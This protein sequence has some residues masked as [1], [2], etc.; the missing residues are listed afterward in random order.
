MFSDYDIT[1][2]HVWTNLLEGMFFFLRFNCSWRIQHA[3]NSLRGDPS[4][5]LAKGARICPLAPKIFHNDLGVEGGEVYERYVPGSTH[6][7]GWK[8]DPLNEDGKFP[9]QNGDTTYCYVSLP[10]GIVYYWGHGSKNNLWTSSVSLCFTY[11]IHFDSLCFKKTPFWFSM[12]YYVSKDS[13]WFTMFP[14]WFTI[15]LNLFSGI[16]DHGTFGVIRNLPWW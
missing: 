8:M 15:F 16:M 1:Y 5:L 12:F 3:Q 6:I 14:F 4:Q 13:L 11:G 2:I 7:A 10:Q 9:I